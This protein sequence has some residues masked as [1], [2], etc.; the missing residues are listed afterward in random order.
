MKFIFFLQ[1]NIRLIFC[2]SYINVQENG[3]VYQPE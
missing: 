3:V 2:L 1:M